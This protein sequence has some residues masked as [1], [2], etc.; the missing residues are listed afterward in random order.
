[1]FKDIVNSAVLRLC[2]VI[3][4][5]LLGCFKFL[6]QWS[7]IGITLYVY[8]ISRY[9]LFKP[10]LTT[11][12]FPFLCSIAFESSL[13]FSFLFF[14][15]FYSMKCNATDVRSI[16]LFANL[17]QT[18][19]VQCDILLMKI[20][21]CNSTIPRVHKQWRNYIKFNYTLRLVVT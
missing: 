21:F 13:E 18:L 1:M 6:L 7:V 19:L 4:S 11:K 16:S 14:L 3:C 15:C 20:F 10:C 8:T 12:L 9:L 5:F 17:K 2:R